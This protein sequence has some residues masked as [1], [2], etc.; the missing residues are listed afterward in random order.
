[1]RRTAPIA[2]GAMVIM[3]EKWLGENLGAGDNL[4]DRW[5]ALLQVE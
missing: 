3:N 4:V 5:A 2:L 1:M